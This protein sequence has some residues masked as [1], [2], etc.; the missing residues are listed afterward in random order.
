M[1]LLFNVILSLLSIGVIFLDLYC[2]AIPRFVSLLSI[3]AL[4]A[5]IVLELIKEK[6]RWKKILFTII[7]ILVIVFVF[8]GTYCNP[9]RNSLTKRKINLDE[10]CKSAYNQTLTYRDAK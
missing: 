7:N 8:F 6:H 9:Y 2:F 4:F 3:V 5:V 10:L 1:L